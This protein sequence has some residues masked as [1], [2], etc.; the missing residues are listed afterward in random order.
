VPFLRFSCIFCLGFAAF[1]S[2]GCAEEEPSLKEARAFDAYDVYYAGQEAAGFPLREV[3]GENPQRHARRSA[4]VF[5][6]G[7]CVDPPDEGGCPPPLQIHNYSTCSWWAAASNQTRPIGFKSDPMYD[8]RGAKARRTGGQV[9]EARVE[10]FTGDTTVKISGEPNAI[11]TA[12]RTLRSV[13]EG[14]PTSHLP[15]PVPGSLAGKLPCQ[16]EWGY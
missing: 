11:K 14:Q 3:F 5:I 12:A 2:S 1:L 16:D 9:G 15:P 6:Y 10:I 13:D 4:W 8:F 7:Q